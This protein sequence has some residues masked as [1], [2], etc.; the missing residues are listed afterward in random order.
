MNGDEL[1]NICICGGGN[2]GTVIAGVAAARGWHVN[3]LTR[4]PDRWKDM[5]EVSDSE[6]KRFVGALDAISSEPADVIPGSGIVL[7]CL[8][9]MAM[10]EELRRIKPFLD[11]NTFVGSVF[12]CTGF[13]VMA[14]KEL[15]LDAKLFGFQ[16]PPFIAR[17]N[18]YGESGL[19]LGYRKTMRVGFWGTN[20]DDVARL[21]DV[22]ENMLMT[23]LL[24]LRHPFQATL[25]NSNPILHTTRLYDMFSRSRGP[26]SVI[27]CFYEDW[28][29]SSSD[30]LIAADAEFQSLLCKLGL[31]D[32]DIPP[33]IEYYE[34]TDASSLSRKIRSITAFKGLPAP[35]KELAA[36][37]FVPDMESR[38]FTEDF[39]YGLL[40]IKLVCDL[41]S[42][43]TPMI[44]RILTWYQESVNRK[45]LEGTHVADSDDVRAVGSLDR[46]ILK[47]M[48]T[49]L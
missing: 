31:D 37:Q 24:P 23:P 20:E 7:V 29:D 39:T 25:T 42:V 18:R 2:L 28:T 16:R 15:G 21:S 4:H 41:E 47:Q 49:T 5:L 46:E 44:D 43:E 8:P 6:G 35:M 17:V 3:I 27:P 26:L 38:Y 10:S 19:L 45:Y 40:M 32:G 33:L 9:A 11:K 22:L 13:F 48:I 12:C 34:S 1:K 30:V 14:L 36:G